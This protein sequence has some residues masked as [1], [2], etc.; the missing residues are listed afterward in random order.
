MGGSDCP[1]VIVDLPK[2]WI[3]RHSVRKEEVLVETN[4]RAD[5]LKLGMVPHVKEL[6]AKLESAAPLLAED[7]RLEERQVPVV[8]TG[9]AQGVEGQVVKLSSRSVRKGRRIEPLPY[10][11][12]IRDFTGEVGPIGCVLQ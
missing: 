4:P 10:S 6:C 11:F 2:V 5:V 1:E 3:P 8:A 7:K 9:A 12:W